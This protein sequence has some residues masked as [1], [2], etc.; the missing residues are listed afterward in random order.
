MDVH[1]ILL[2]GIYLIILA[3]GTPSAQS[4]LLKLL[5]SGVRNYIRD[6]AQMRCCDNERNHECFA[7]RQRSMS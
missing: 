3:R 5:S 2:Q 7:S 4:P 6:Y 1:F